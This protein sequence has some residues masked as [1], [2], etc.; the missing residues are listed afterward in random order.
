MMDILELK[1]AAHK[2]V[3]ANGMRWYGLVL[4]RPEKDVLMKAMVHEVDGKRKQ[5]RLMMKWRKQV[6]GNTRRI[7]LKK[8]AADWCR[9]RESVRRVAEVVK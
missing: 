2:L 4:R 8:D 9:W 3:R 6:E 5:G 1:E 7:G